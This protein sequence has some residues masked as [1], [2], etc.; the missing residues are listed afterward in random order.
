ML[1][2]VLRIH[3]DGAY[4][5]N[6][7]CPSGLCLCNVKKKCAG[8]G[9][10]GAFVSLRLF[11]CVLRWGM[12]GEQSAQ[13]RSGLYHLHFCALLVAGG[14]LESQGGLGFEKNLELGNFPLPVFVV[15]LYR[16]GRNTVYCAQ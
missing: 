10:V 6:L 4:D 2:T 11:P 1:G 8:R 12:E 15:C 5:S 14:G 13:A 16:G 3:R 9:L 7:P